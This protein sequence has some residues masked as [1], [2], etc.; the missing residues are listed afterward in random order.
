MDAIPQPKKTVRFISLGCPKNLVDTETY[1]GILNQKDYAIVPADQPSDIGVINTCGFIGPS[2]QESIDTICEWIEEKKAGRLDM[3][4]VT[5][6]LA[7]RYPQALTDEFSEVDAFLGTS[8]YSRLDFII[9]EKLAQ[10]P[11]RNFISHQRENPRWDL[12]RLSTQAHSRYIKISEGCSHSCSFCT[13]PLMRGGLMSRSLD[14]VVQ[15]VRHASQ[16]GTKEFNFIAQ[17]LNEYGR[18]LKPRTSLTA[19]FEALAPLPGKIWMRPLYMYPLQFPD[20]LIKVMKDHPHLIPY[21]DIP[22]QH[23]DDTLLKSMHRGSSSRYIHRLISTLRREIPEI[24]LRTTFITGYPGETEAAFQKLRDFIEATTFD[25]VGIFTYSEEE[26]TLAGGL[27]EQIPEDVKVQRRQELME[28]QQK[29]TA[30]RKRA[31]KGRSFTVLFD[32]PLSLEELELIPPE[33]HHKNLLGRGRYYGQ[34]PEIDGHIYLYTEDLENP[35]P[36]AGCWL[37]A[38]IT[39]TYDYDMAASVQLKKG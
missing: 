5:G 23:I 21:V 8:E 13:I 36:E 24:V 3:L 20:R 30:T 22:L 25:H 26:G 16:A 38:T 12:P 2:K 29:I 28:L 11:K 6:C 4:I 14:D 15:E 10:K 34:A 18:D 31:L 35:L 27:T 1:A 33:L 7:A 37:E 19:L 39:S 32:S 17:D 9:R